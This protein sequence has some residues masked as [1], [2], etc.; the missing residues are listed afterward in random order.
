[1]GIAIQTNEHIGKTPFLKIDNT[2]HK[3]EKKKMCEPHPHKRTG[4]VKL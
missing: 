2:F 3:Y 4:Q 1:M